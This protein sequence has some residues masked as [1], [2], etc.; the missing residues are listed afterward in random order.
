[1]RALVVDDLAKGREI[2]GERLVEAG[3]EV[4]Y[5]QD[6]IE[7]L[8][9]LRK[10]RPDLIVS[11][12]QMPRLDGMGLLR[13][14]RELSDV[15]FVMITDF[16]SIPDCEA[17]MRRG[18]DRYLQFA[19]D[20][21][22]IG[23]V[24]RSLV[25]SMADEGKPLADPDRPVTAEEAR[26]RAQVDLRAELQHLV[27]ECHGNIAEIARRMAR[28]RSTVRYHLRRFGLLEASSSAAAPGR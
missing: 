15:P 28:D 16:G 26:I 17:A 18:A 19:Q 27:V 21:D 10:L 13:R 11:D 4:S 12:F 1:M 2:L 5:A 24:A 3:F 23:V 7:A 9:V 20:V 14:V 25:E 8:G 22:R 6:G